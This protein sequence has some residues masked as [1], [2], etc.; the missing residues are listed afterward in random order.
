MSIS[1]PIRTFRTPRTNQNLVLCWARPIRIKTEI[2]QRV[3]WCDSVFGSARVVWLVIVTNKRRWWAVYRYPSL[4][5]IYIVGDDVLDLSLLLALLFS[6]S[7]ALSLSCFSLSLFPSPSFSLSFS[8]PRS[9]SLLFARFRPLFGMAFLISHS[10][11][12]DLSLLFTLFASRFLTLLL[13]LFASRLLTT[14]LLFLASRSFPR[15]NLLSEIRWRGRWVGQSV[16]CDYLLET[17]LAVGLFKCRD[18]C[19]RKGYNGCGRST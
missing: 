15:S 10:R 6:R 16:T 13:T 17:I 19:E 11:S 4:S 14:L 12:L 8:L 1:G 2:T 18:V 7:L 3:R 9:L 5:F